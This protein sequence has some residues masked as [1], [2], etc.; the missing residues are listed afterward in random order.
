MSGGIVLGISRFAVGT[1]NH[2][3]ASLLWLELLLA[4]TFIYKGK[5]QRSCRFAEGVSLRSLGSSPGVWGYQLRGK[6]VP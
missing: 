3:T 6:G 2:V 4:E 1:S 5:P